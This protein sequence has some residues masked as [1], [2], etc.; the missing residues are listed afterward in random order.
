MALA[1]SED[2][3]IVATYEVRRRRGLEMLALVG[4]LGFVGLGIWMML[5]Q[6]TDI[7]EKGAGALGVAFFGWCAIIIV[8]MMSRGATVR[9]SREG[10]HCA[11]APRYDQLKVIPW[12]DI[13]GFGISELQRQK[14]NFIRLA[15]TDA[16]VRQFSARETAA[17]LK[18]FRRTMGFATAAVIV[19]GANAE[20]DDA[21][22]IA[23]VSG[24]KAASLADMFRFNRRNFGGEICLSWV[25]RDRSAQRFHEL[26]S[27]WKAVCG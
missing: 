17:A 26:L 11:F 13:E 23:E 16:L 6:E 20:F 9:L 7:A 22:E 4:A 25:F 10:L 21:R 14:F 2:P 3:A 5:D 18:T 1:R 19:A 15:R 24:G 12:R 8:G 27:A